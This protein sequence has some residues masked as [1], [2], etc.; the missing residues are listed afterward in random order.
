MRQDAAW[1]HAERQAGPAPSPPPSCPGA[2]CPKSSV[3]AGPCARGLST[4]MPASEFAAG[5]PAE[6]TGGTG[7]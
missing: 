2:E 7:Q 1:G 5:N 3:P 4:T 6:P